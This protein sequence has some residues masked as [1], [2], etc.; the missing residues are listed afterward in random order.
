MSIIDMYCDTLLA[1]C[2]GDKNLA[3]NDLM[4][5][6]E[7]LAAGGAMAQ[8][9]AAFLPPD[10][11][12]E[13]YAPSLSYGSDAY[14]IFLALYDCYKKEIDVNVDRI[15]HAFSYDDV[16][17]N[18]ANGKISSILT[19]EDGRLLDNKIERLDD[20]YEK[21]VRL[22]TLTWNY[23]NCIGFPHSVDS[24]LNGKGLKKIQ[25]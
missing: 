14:D 20:L 4:I 8:F 15:S 2:F 25:I 16:I 12:I 23:E 24:E 17:E 5:D 11:A 18:N 22:I 10:E 19:V 21:G 6:L 1:C 3:R 9:F 13:E 7:R